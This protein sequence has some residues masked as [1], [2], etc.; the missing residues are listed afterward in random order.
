MTGI[1]W[2]LVTSPSETGRAHI[3]IAT[4]DGNQV[5]RNLTGG[6]AADS[7]ARCVSSPKHRVYEFEVG[8]YVG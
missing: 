4:E 5:A 8:S 6:A 2:I 7:S 1:N 3:N